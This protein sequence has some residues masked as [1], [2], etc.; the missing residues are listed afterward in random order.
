[1]QFG[2]TP[3]FY[4]LA[5]KEIPNDTQIKEICVE[6]SMEGGYPN[7]PHRT[8][9]WGVANGMLKLHCTVIIRYTSFQAI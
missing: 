5:L 7:F 4:N 3:V 2:F 8:E 9:N 6:H 1:M